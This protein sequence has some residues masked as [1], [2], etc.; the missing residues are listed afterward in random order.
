MPPRSP[1][2][3]YLPSYRLAP[4]YTRSPVADEAVQITDEGVMLRLVEY[5]RTCMYVCE[6]VHG[7]SNILESLKTPGGAGTHTGTGYR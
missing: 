5:V 4:L 7:I 2:G 1:S 6:P 3:R